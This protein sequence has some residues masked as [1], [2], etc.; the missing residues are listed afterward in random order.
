MARKDAKRKPA[1]ARPALADDL[2]SPETA[3]V[4]VRPTI[5]SS[6]R[7]E[8]SSLAC[9]RCRSARYHSQLELHCRQNPDKSDSEAQKVSQTGQDRWVLCCAPRSGRLLVLMAPRHPD[10]VSAHSWTR[11]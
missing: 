1:A 10:L 4:R 9:A 7:N 2:T 11:A 8:I 5:V 3:G 6:D